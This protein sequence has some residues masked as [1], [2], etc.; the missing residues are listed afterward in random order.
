M[1]VRMYLYFYLFKKPLLFQS[2]SPAP[3]LIFL[4][5]LCFYVFGFS[6][7]PRHLLA[8][9]GLVNLTNQL[10]NLCLVYS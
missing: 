1:Y 3:L 7:T 10:S 6:L 8:L 9:L 2:Y 4:F 5:F